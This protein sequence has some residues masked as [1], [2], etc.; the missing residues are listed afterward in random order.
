MSVLFIKST[1]FWIDCLLLLLDNDSLLLMT[2][3]RL[4]GILFN[5]LHHPSPSYLAEE[6]YESIW[7]KIFGKVDLFQ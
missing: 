6:V 2:V 3:T 7:S 4:D 5:L 1:N